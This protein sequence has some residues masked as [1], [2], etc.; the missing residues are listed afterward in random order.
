MCMSLPRVPLNPDAHL[1]TRDEIASSKVTL[2]ETKDQQRHGCVDK[3]ASLADTW[4]LFKGAA[5]HAEAW[6]GA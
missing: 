1:K 5:R 3:P 4:R 2:P 6:P